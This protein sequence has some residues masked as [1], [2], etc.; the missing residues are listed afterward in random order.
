MPWFEPQLCSCLLSLLG[1]LFQQ[2]LFCLLHLV[3]SSY[4]GTLCLLVSYCLIA[5]FLVEP[6]G[7]SSFKFMLFL[8]FLLL[9]L[10]LY[11][12]AFLFNSSR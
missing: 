4:P 12:V 8:S 9:F 11:T 1:L 3:L 6:P 5:S 2:G 10:C 7:Y